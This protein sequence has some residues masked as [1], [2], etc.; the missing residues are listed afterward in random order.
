MDDEGTDED[1]G[2]MEKK[3]VGLVYI[4]YLTKNH[5]ATIKRSANHLMADPAAL[6]TVPPFIAESIWK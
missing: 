4:L 6:N 2:L 1:D 5:S 3:L